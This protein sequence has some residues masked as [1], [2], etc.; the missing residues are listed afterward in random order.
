MSRSNVF[1]KIRS[2]IESEERVQQVEDVPAV[3]PHCELPVT[4]TELTDG[5]EVLKRNW[6]CGY[7]GNTSSGEPDKSKE[8]AFEAFHQH[9]KR[10][11]EV[12]DKHGIGGE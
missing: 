8:Q 4:A 6:Y 10:I 7:C 9:K 3:C 11:D 2:L 12:A 5:D 1:D